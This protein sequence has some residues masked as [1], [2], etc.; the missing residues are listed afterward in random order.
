MTEGNTSNRILASACNTSR[1]D[2][3]WIV[4]FLG[5]LKYGKNRFFT[6]PGR[7]EVK[8]P[9]GDFILTENHFLASIRETRFLLNNK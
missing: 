3:E 8:R 4:G 5:T 1:E 9:R 7:R 6:E 2:A